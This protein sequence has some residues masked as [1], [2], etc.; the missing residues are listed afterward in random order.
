[1]LNNAKNLVMAH[2]NAD[3]GSLLPV[4]EYVLDLAQMA[5]FEEWLND[6]WWVATSQEKGV[7]FTPGCKIKIQKCGRFMKRVT[8]Y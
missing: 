6:N 7:M 8:I 2:N 3:T 4:G 1:M 5:E